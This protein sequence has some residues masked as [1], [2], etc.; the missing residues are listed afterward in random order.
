MITN[1]VLTFFFIDLIEC[2]TVTYYR[3]VVFD[4]NEILPLIVSS[5][6]KN[7]QVLICYLFGLIQPFY[8]FKNIAVHTLFRENGRKRN[9]YPLLAT[10]TNILP[11]QIDQIVF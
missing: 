8:N 11:I 5:Y 9:L 4:R 1:P 7:W 10:F 3:S 6:Q 2:I